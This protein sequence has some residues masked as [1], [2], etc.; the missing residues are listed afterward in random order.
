[1][2]KLPVFP[3]RTLI[4]SPRLFHQ[5]I[6]EKKIAK[7]TGDPSSWTDVL[8]TI[9]C[10]VQHLIK[11]DMTK[12]QQTLKTL[13]DVEF[14]NVELESKLSAMT[15]DQDEVLG[16]LQ[17]SVEDYAWHREERQAAN[18]AWESTKS[19][20]HNK[21]ST[22]D[23]ALETTKDEISRSF[24]D[25]FNGAIEQSKAVNLNL[26]VSMFLSRTSWSTMSNIIAEFYHF[27]KLKLY[28]TY[29]YLLKSD[30]FIL[31]YY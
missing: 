30:H 25:D 20:L 18:R 24:M 7:P 11:L 23:T 2:E 13:E 12:L 31:T 21:I 28:V 22:L 10:V 14:C 17:R 19:M 8:S 5:P 15:Q 1:V 16:K 29:A 9:D 26:D 6:P 27:E 3:N 4:S